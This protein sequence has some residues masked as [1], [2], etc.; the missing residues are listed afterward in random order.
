MT[1]R[2]KIDLDLPAHVYRSH[3]SLFYVDFN[4]KWHCLGKDWNESAKK[5]WVVLS[6]KENV[7]QGSM[8]ELIDR[9]LEEIAIKKAVSSYRNNLL[10]A[11]NLRAVFGKMRPEDIKPK[12]VYAYLDLRGKNAPSAA[13]REKALLS[14]M[15]T[16]GIRWGLIEVNP[17]RDVRKISIDKRTR[18]I[19]DAEFAAVKAV[20]SE[21]VR[22]IMDFAYLTG[23]RI[24]DVLEVRLTDLLDD[25][26]LIEQNKSGGKV[27][28][29]VLWNDDLRRLVASIRAMDK[30][31]GSVFLF[32]GRGGHPYTYGGFSSMFRRFVQKAGV[33]DF[34][35]HDIRAKSLTDLKRAGGDAQ[36]LAGHQSSE[37]T[38]H[39]VKRREIERVVPLSFKIG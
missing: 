39:Y 15:F 2:R 5:Q 26:I 19:T 33:L 20:S 23:Q 18:Y 6:E 28:L 9:Y 38:D 17:C 3:G 35:F 16:I 32:H 25:G 11:Q 1:R 21:V 7:I 34:H 27:R 37:M 29:L 4:K 36:L 10:E 24:G 14:H 12:H 8:A 30:Q 22:L 31:C 13:N